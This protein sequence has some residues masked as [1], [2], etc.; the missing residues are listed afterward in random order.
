[1]SISGG[2]AI[3]FQ[4]YNT[5]AVWFTDLIILA[6]TPANETIP[7]LRKDLTILMIN[8]TQDNRFPIEIVRE[9]AELVKHQVAKLTL[10]ELPGDHFFFLSKTQEWRTAIRKHAN[11]S[12]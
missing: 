9:R 11:Y 6:S 10:V 8:G 2:G 4:I 7:Q 12:P 5:N 3:S 1:M